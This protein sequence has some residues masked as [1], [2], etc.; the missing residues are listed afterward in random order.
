MAPALITLSHEMLA[1]G[2]LA[3]VRVRWIL[4]VPRAFLCRW[5]LTDLS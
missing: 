5:C 1:L 3:S 2:T 4:Y